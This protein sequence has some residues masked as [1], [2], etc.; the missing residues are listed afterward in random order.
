MNRHGIF[1]KALSVGLSLLLLCGIAGLAPLLSLRGASAGAP[2]GLLRVR[3]DGTFRILQIADLQD[4]YTPKDGDLGEVNIYF[5]EINTIRLAIARVQPDLIVLTG[6]NIFGAKGTLSDGMTVFEYTV[7]KVTEL[8]GDIPFIVTFGNHDEESN[9]RDTAGADRLSEAEQLAIYERYGALPL[10]T[11]I[12]PGDTSENATAKYGTGYVDI[13]DAAGRTVVQRVILVNSGA[14]DGS[15]KPAQ[16]GRTGVNAVSY[17]DEY[18]D[19]EKVVAAVERWTAAPEIKCI[20]FQ[21]IPLQE[22]YYGDADETRLLVNSD[23]GQRAPNTCAGSGISGKYAASP[24]NPTLTG[25]YN[26][27]SGCSYASTRAFYNALANKPNVVGCFFGHDHHD[28]L[29]GR[30]TVEGRS[31]TL[32]WGGGLLVDPAGYPDCTYYAYNPLVSAY[33]LTGDGRTAQSLAETKRLYTYYGLLRDYDMGDFSREDT[34]ISEVRLFAADTPG[35][36]EYPDSYVGYFEEAKAKCVA[37][38]FIPLETCYTRNSPGNA[39]FHTVADFNFG[40]YKNK[41]FI[42]GAKAVCLGYKT[43]NDPAEAITDIRIYDG[44]ADPPAKWTRQEIWAYQNNSQNSGGD[45]SYANDTDDAVPFYNANFDWN[46]GYTAGTLR[47]DTNAQIGFNEGMTALG[48]SNNAWLYYTKDPAAGTPIKRIFVD[49]TD[50]QAYAG[51]FNKNR[52]N[53]EYPYTFVQ[54]LN[55]ACDLDRDNA[56]FNVKM[57]YTG[58]FTGG[59]YPDARGA[60]AYLGVVRAVETHSHG[61]V[62]EEPSTE[63]STEPATDPETPPY[64]DPVIEP[65]PQPETCSHICHSTNPFLRVVWKV[66]NFFN[67]LFGINKTCAC[68]E[69]HW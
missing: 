29:A 9:S 7:K 30:V 53:T 42:S 11:D 63:P 24:A 66:L 32:G 40:C 23:D 50:T 10:Q 18:N 4:H 36:P 13:Y 47:T 52:F 37:A 61:T 51:S 31:L 8:F 64:T 22:I 1:K 41:D 56:A 65:R 19:Y 59:V 38:G 12:T 14:Y 62:P 16:Y 3:A 49:I 69:A 26:E 5:R 43:T 45:R 68:G 33:T 58:D 28:T 46:A 21:H 35:M 15:R 39:S 48:P 20:A 34:Y 17:T 27:Y 44:S 67:R 25:K 57:G 55:A 2:E 6:D 60:W 54:D